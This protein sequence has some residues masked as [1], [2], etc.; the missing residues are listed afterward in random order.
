MFG[1]DIFL[2]L[3]CGTCAT[4]SFKKALWSK[5]NKGERIDKMRWIGRNKRKRKGSGTGIFF[6]RL[7]KGKEKKKYEKKK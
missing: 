1:I 6:G 7:K 5:K 4:Q 2:F 3:A